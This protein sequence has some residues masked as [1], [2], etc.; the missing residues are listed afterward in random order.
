MMTRTAINLFINLILM[1][2]MLLLVVSIF[3][4][5]N[6]ND[7]NLLHIIAGTLIFASS[8]LHIILHWKWIKTVVFH[9]P[10]DLPKKVR[11]NRTTVAWLSIPFVLCG[12]TGIIT[13]LVQSHVLTTSWLTLDDL[14][15]LHRLMGIAAFIPIVIHVVQNGKWYLAIFKRRFNPVPGRRLVTQLSFKEE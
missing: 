15:W 9:S 10:K 2:S 1:A 13:A 4:A 11:A 12:I 8:I 5:H 14:K 7:V 6:S 3:G